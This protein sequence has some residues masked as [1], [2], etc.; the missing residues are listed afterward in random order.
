M[1]F[2]EEFRAEDIK[3]ESDA[4]TFYYGCVVDNGMVWDTDR[5]LYRSDGT[6]AVPVEDC[7]ALQVLDRANTIAREILAEQ[8]VDAQEIMDMCESILV[9]NSV[10]RVEPDLDGL[11][12]RKVKGYANESAD[13]KMR[14]RA[15]HLWG[16]MQTTLEVC[17]PNFVPSK[18][19]IAVPQGFH[20]VIDEYIKGCVSRI[21]VAT[22][23]VSAKD[24]DDLEA[25]MVAH[26]KE[27]QAQGKIEPRDWDSLRIDPDSDENDDDPFS[28]G[29]W[30]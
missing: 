5:G 18:V 6:P 4:V 10:L 17:I 25:D 15:M 3:T 2:E 26:G 20:P 11:P 7:E 28:S 27:L 9:C 13:Q 23:T 19:G 1:E 8:E 29:M 14:R 16:V 30:A 12:A 22:K 24:V 21:P